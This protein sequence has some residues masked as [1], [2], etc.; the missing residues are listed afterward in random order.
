MAIFRFLL[1]KDALLLAFLL[2]VL[3]PAGAKADWISSVKSDGVAYFFYDYPARTDRYDLT[4]GQWLSS[5]SLPSIRGVV[6][7]AHA[8][9][10]GIYVGYGRSIYRYSLDGL[11]EAHLL[12]VDSEVD[13]IFS[14][15]SFVYVVYGS[16]IV[17][18]SKSDNGMAST[19]TI[20]YYRGKGFSILGSG[21]RAFFVGSSNIYF[22][23]LNE[24]GTL[25]LIHI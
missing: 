1:S 25:S 7:C 19:S 18:F 11:E 13:E 3:F 5:I 16:K 21:K 6:T 23:T 14:N 10:D 12:N 8:D 2:Y 20:G 4:D 24:D 15:E 9:K 17:S 22:L